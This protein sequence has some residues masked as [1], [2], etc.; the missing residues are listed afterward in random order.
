MFKF[1]I[2]G[3]QPFYMVTGQIGHRK[4]SCC[5]TYTFIKNEMQITDMDYQS[6]FYNSI[7]TRIYQ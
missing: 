5:K 7:L 4:S 2:L 6:F 3:G 1:I